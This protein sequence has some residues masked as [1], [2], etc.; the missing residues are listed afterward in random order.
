MPIKVKLPDGRV[1]DIPAGMTMPQVQKLAQD[2][3]A[4]KLPPVDLGIRIE[5]PQGPVRQE[6]DEGFNLLRAPSTEENL[7]GLA[8]G[9]IGLKGKLVS[10]PLAAAGGALGEGVRQQ[11]ERSVFENPIQAVDPT[12]IAEAAARQ[13]GL[14]T[15]G[16]G[17]G[18]LLGQGLSRAGTALAGIPKAAQAAKT[19]QREGIP[20]TGKTAPTTN[21]IND[22]TGTLN[23][24]I[25]QAGGDVPT[26]EIL[27]SAWQV[28]Q[29]AATKGQFP[30]DATDDVLDVLA[31]FEQQHGPTI[32]LQQVQQ[33]K[34]RAG[35]EQATQ[36]RKR[37]TEPAATGWTKEAELALQRAEKGAVEK[38]VPEA[39]R[40]NQQ[41][42]DLKDLRRGQKTAENRAGM[43]A[44]PWTMAGR[45]GAGALGGP[46]A[47]LASSDPFMALLAALAP[48]LATPA[49]LTRAGISV[50]RASRVVPTAVRT[51]VQGADVRRRKPDPQ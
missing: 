5:E 40:L 10:V 26:R 46:A 43:F 50:D 31:R 12:R 29:D 30:A 41:I 44:S 21:R 49:N 28:V 36:I 45:V 14:E 2:L 11:R 35:M 47:Y 20:L 13:G 25:D 18:K 6:N 1:I 27:D 4:G 7:G 33:K 24:A 8:G 3:V 19:I 42:G 39:A 22:V 15:I 17:G 37:A 16:I 23:A 32:P 48:F 51:A 38:R 9:F 34:V